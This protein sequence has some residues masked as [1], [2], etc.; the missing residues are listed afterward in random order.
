MKKKILFLLVSIISIMLT[1]SAYIALKSTRYDDFPHF[2]QA[3]LQYNGTVCVYTNTPLFLSFVF[4]DKN[5]MSEMASA[6]NIREISLVDESRNSYFLDDW[7]IENGTIHNE[8]M[9]RKISGN[10]RLD[11]NGLL[12]IKQ[13]KMLFADGIEKYFDV[14]HLIIDVQSVDDKTV[15]K[16][17]LDIYPDFIMNL[18]TKSEITGLF[19]E[20]RNFSNKVDHIYI[21]N[22]DLGIVGLSANLAKAIVDNSISDINILQ[23]EFRKNMLLYERFK[24]VAVEN[25]ELFDVNLLL[26]FDREINKSNYLLVPISKAKDYQ[27]NCQILIF[28]PKITV[29]VGN[30][31]Y[32]YYSQY[33]LLY[34]PLINIDYDPVKFLKENGK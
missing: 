8:Y 24:K 20:I 15:D 1:T 17:P 28:N 32:D 29:A 2:K 34:I 10:V 16:P 14:G 30:I 6:E 11:K 23:E 4:I 22:I 25:N 5:I 33:P 27:Q 7:V 9:F 3:L 18:E 26:E 13:L 12:K 21:E 31:K 19:I